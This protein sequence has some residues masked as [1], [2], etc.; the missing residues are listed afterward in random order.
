LSAG[1]SAWLLTWVALVL[2]SE[3]AAGAAPPLVLSAV[4]A[5]AYLG[6]AF[7]VLT[8]VDSLVVGEYLI[9]RKGRYVPNVVRHLMLGAGVVAAGVMILRVVMNINLLALVV[10]P[11]VAAAVVGVALKDTLARFFAGIELGK[12]VKEG[13]WITTLEREGRVMHIGLEH[14]TLLTRE[15]DYVTIPNDNVIQSGVTNYS[16]PTTTHLCS[17]YVEAAYRTSPADV[18]TTLVD[19]ASAV[20]GV[21]NDPKPIA[22]V[23]AFNESGIQYRV[24]FPIADYAR[25]PEIESTVR[26]YVWNAF[27]RKGIEIPF[28]QRVIQQ[29][30]V[31]ERSEPLGLG[32]IRRHLVA[33]DFLAALPS[34]QLEAVVRASRTEQFLPGGAG[35]AAR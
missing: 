1:F 9:E 16:R 5:A 11:T 6:I 19:S 18:C 29:S 10:L 32:D 4:D 24:K 13:D 25:R 31:A 26:T 12:M 20:D 33:V 30:A 7:L 34:M 14:V 21:L 2:H 23:T 22:M 3:W 8:I 28:P 15:R 35:G 27:C 17:V